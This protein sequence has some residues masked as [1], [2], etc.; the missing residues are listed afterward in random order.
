MDPV[1]L[2]ILA[3]TQIA[4]SAIGAGIQRRQTR[5]AARDAFTEEEERRLRELQD[6][7]AADE[8]GLT[9][10]ESLAL[11]AQFR[12]QAAAQSRATQAERLAQQ[13]ARP[14]SARDVFL[15][16]SADQAARQMATTEQN[17]QRLQAEQAAQ[18]AQEAEMQRL[19][20]ARSQ[21]AQI[22]AGA[23]S[24]GAAVATGI[25]E[26]TPEIL[27]AAMEQQLLLERD[28]ALLEAYQ[29]DQITAYDLMISGAM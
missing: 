14:T 12:Q 26:Q 20:L 21:A 22:M 24:A 4:G 6:L 1:T 15:Q 11:E 9:E 10:A 27:G 8:L 2:A 29:T 18:Q 16:A 23:P 17:L 25:A 28:A 19:L 5:A 13:A 3:G 7:Q